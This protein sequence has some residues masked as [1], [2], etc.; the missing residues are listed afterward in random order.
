M[1][2]LVLTPINPVL[3]IDAYTKIT[4]YFEQKELK[5]NALC[6]PFFAQMKVHLD[7]GE[8]IP[9]FFSMIEKSLEKEMGRKLYNSKNMVVVGN[10]YKDQKFDHVISFDDLESEPFD[11]YIETIKTEEWKEFADRVNV[12]NLY[13]IEDTSL[14][15]P[16]IDHVNL[17]LISTLYPNK[18]KH[19]VVD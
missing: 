17:F 5:L 2:I 10:T 1:R 3:A 15:L 4:N 12:N 19:T 9:T 8:Y 14:Q 7:G 13:G 11:S 18:N 16:T 6:F